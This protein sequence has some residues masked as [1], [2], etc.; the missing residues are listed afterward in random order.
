MTRIPFSLLLSCS[1]MLG[2][3]HSSDDDDTPLPLP[4]SEVQFTQYTESQQIGALGE[5]D[6]VG[7]TVINELTGTA[8]TLNARF[9]VDENGQLIGVESIKFPENGAAISIFAYSPYREDWN[10]LTDTYRT[11]EVPTDQSL[12]ELYHSAD[13]II[14]LPEG[15]NPVTTTDVRL[16]FTH[17]FAQVNLELTDPTEKVSLSTAEVELGP[18]ATSAFVNPRTGEV[19]AIEASTGTVTPYPTLSSHAAQANTRSDRRETYSAIVVPQAMTQ[20][21]PFL[22]VRTGGRTYNFSVP[23]HVEWQSGMTYDYAVE[24]T[25]N[26][27]SLTSTSISK[28]TDQDDADNLYLDTTL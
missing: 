20:G 28:W 27:L 21:T 3:C 8:T 19:S 24:I 9:I 14:G 4:G 7:M 22:E 2:A 18:I 17:A 1:L 13:F 23:D 25:S 10:N 12:Y 26:G 6:E 5:G 15:G 16:V 11:I